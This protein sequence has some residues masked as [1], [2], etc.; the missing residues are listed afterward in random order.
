V[1]VPLE[2]TEP[3]TAAGSA[4]FRAEADAV[5]VHLEVEGLEPLDPP[6][7]YEAWLYTTDGRILSI[8]QLT[9]EEGTF[10]G[11]LTARGSLEGFRTFWIT[12]EPDARDPAHDGDTVLRGPVPDLR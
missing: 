9:G 5:R 12:A 8:G 4:T 3:F 7:V 2:S 6:G 11:E 1:A 10:S